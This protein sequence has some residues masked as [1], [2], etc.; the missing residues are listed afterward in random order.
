[1]IAPTGGARIRLVLLLGILT[2]LG[3]FTVDMY[4]PALPQITQEFGTSDTMVQL[5]LT[6]TLLGLA[7][8]QLLIGP[9]SDIYGRRRPLLVGTVIHVAA[10]LACFFAPSIEVLTALRTL[11]G[12]GAAAT[13]VIAM[14]IVRDLFTGHDAA[15]V[16][17]RLMLVMGV[18]PI[19]A[20]SIGGALMSVTQWRGVFLALFLLGIAMIALAAVSLPETLAPENRSG[21][22]IGAIARNYIALVKD[23][24]FMVLVLVCGL[25]RGV[26]WSYIAASSY[27]MQEQF[28]LSATAYGFAFAGGA[29]V[30]IGSSQL[31]VV[32]LG[33]WSPNSITIW[34]MWGSSGVG[35]AFVVVAATGSWGFV[36]FAVPILL[37][38]C[39]TGFVMPN[40]PAVALSRHGEAAGSAAALIGF[41][42]FGAAAVVAPIVGLLGNTSLAVAISMTGASV[43]GV[44]ALLCVRR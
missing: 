17:S 42:Q 40:A 36:G 33:R 34:A 6:G 12:F 28:G 24:H 13:G 26:L 2:A 19:L 9:L 5:T 11:Q 1:M 32:L 38:L 39:A 35:A 15:V 25:G 21:K 31:N 10:S 8:G 29:L 27:V 44:I 16:L 43:L 23:A 41:A 30:L 18:A 14:A 7:F 37:M 20:P 4:L 3:P 22:G